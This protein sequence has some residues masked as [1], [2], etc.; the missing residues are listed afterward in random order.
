M[1]IDLPTGTVTFL[2]TDIEGSTKLAQEHRDIW[3]SLRARHHAIQQ[4]AMDVHNGYV[5]Q[6]IGDAFCVAFHNAGDALL[7]ALKSQIDLNQEKWGET[8]IK[9]RMGIH[10]GKAE[11]QADGGYIGYTSM[12]R[13]QRLMSAGHGGQTL[14]SMAAQELVRDEL[15]EGVVLRDMGEH[16]LKDLIHP[17]HIYQVNFPGLPADFPA[18]KTLD[19][20][21]NNLPAQ[22]TPFV[23]RE[24]EIAALLGLLRDPYVRMVTLTGAGGTGK[25]RL[26][27]QVAAELLDEYEHG[28]WFVELDSI[29]DPGLVL[30]AI[31]SVLKVKESAGMPL[32]QRL[33]EQ[34]NERCLLL[35]LDN[36]EQVIEAAPGIGK[37][38]AAAP[39]VK[40]LTSSREVLHLRGEHD[41]PVPP[42]GLPESRHKQTAAVL[43]QYEAVA[44]FIQHARAAQPA[45]GLTEENAPAVVEICRKLDGLPLAIELAAARSRL[46]SPAVMLEKL[47]DRLNV[48][49]GG[50]RDLPQRQQTIRGT[51]DW[52]YDLLDETE[53][54]LFTR[55][56]V[57]NGGWTL[58]SAEAICGTELPVDVMSGLESLLDKSLV[59]QA[60]ATG[61][62]NR[63]SML[64]T[65]RAY[66]REK[67]AQRGELPGIQKAHA[68]YFNAFLEK[69]RSAANGPDEAA[70]F[71]RLDDNLDNL[72]SA[73][74]WGFA[75]QQTTL[76][77][78]T[79]RLTEYW[80]QRSNFREPL[81]WLE[82]AINLEASASLSELPKAIHGAGNL[83]VDLGEYSR[84]HSYYERSLALFQQSGD[85]MGAMGSLHNLG[86]VAW[87]E[88]DF[89]QARQI[90]EQ[91]LREGTEPG[92]FGHSMVLNNL[93]SLARI[94][95]DWQE[96]KEFYLRSLEIC[97][98][99][100]A[101]AGI[102]Y[103]KWFLGKLALAQCDLV[104]AQTYLESAKKA[105]W[106]SA[107]P[108]IQAY[109]TGILGYIQVLSGNRKEAQSM[110]KATLVS[111][112]EFIR[113]R[114]EK[115]D[116]TWSLFEGQARLELM[117]GRAE[118]AAQLLGV[119]WTQRESD[120][121][122]LTEFE[123]PDYEVAVTKARQ[124]IGDVSFDAAFAKGQKMSVLQAI[125]FALK[126]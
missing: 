65:I 50:A 96:S 1:A 47:K 101:E 83:L 125:E 107:N 124:A 99:L 6:I 57:F 102:S 76:I 121:Y 54:V 60:E 55:L 34:L 66:A 32:E 104:T 2:F 106:V 109:Y 78:R 111:A 4:S 11:I 89:E 23:G 105:S 86:N 73:V 26:S 31:A 62:E 69:V 8:P 122:P 85:K 80:S 108:F 75:Q 18:L 119:S 67:L 41:Y 17:E 126:D 51:I 98:K 3:E 40:V 21:L 53:K 9:V 12:S 114:C 28:V 74:E 45:F 14:L 113:T 29:A 103:A 33:Y 116:E 7:A 71:A 123:R 72:R 61:G 15:P 27:L 16:R 87:M 68:E 20:Q 44:L 59:R 115:I 43:A 63:F 58:E 90:Y 118:R 110:L 79:G 49:T 56:A 82:R 92:S 97:E 88:K 30:P 120:D 52:S 112:E 117:D 70:W 37:L 84:A 94:R 5:F 38:L 81:G 77:L 95:G 25:T 36:F 19:L 35:V 13:V 93:G 22:M 64:E 24:R 46:L 100:E 91:V 48:L 10:P 42:L 39:R